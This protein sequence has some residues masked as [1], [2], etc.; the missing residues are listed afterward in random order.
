MELRIKRIAKR[1]T[2][3]IGH[4]YIDGAYF[5]DT[6]EDTDRGLRQDMP[7]PVIRAKKRQGV[8][9]IPTGR[10]RVTLKVQSQRF[11]K[12][13]IYAFCDGYLPRLINVLGY[14]GVLIH[15]GNTAKDTEGCILVGKNT[16]VGKVLESRVTF[17]KLYARLKEA[18]GDIYI[19][20][21]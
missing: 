20:I 7:M 15:V 17:T 13:A 10:Y 1:D 21:E 3:T 18:K 4:L 9:A 16:K 11:S 14:E 8:T 2:Y 6:L 5:C 12:R 19:K